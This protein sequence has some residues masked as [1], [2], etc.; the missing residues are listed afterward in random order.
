MNLMISMN[1]E[2]LSCR[3]CL[4]IEIFISSL[5]PILRDPTQAI[6]EFNHINFFSDYVLT[7][8]RTKTHIL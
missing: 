3:S 5:C 7:M 6:D 4:V 8:V 1:K 2:N